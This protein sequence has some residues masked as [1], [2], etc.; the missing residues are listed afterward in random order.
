MD[1]TKEIMIESKNGVV[2]DEMQIVSIKTKERKTT[3]LLS[4]GRRI[5][6]I[7]PL[8]EWK[9]ILN[10]KA[11]IE[12]HRGVIVNLKFVC[13]VYDER[14]LLLDGTEE[15]Y[16]KEQKYVDDVTDE[17]I[18]SLFRDRDKKN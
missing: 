13:E 4:S 7:R 18:E 16:E 10:G 12:T 9:E 1:D 15:E 5:E 6:C 3:V 2:V 17:M 8:K 14:I 11:F